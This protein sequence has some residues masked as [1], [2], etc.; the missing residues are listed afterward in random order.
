MIEPIRVVAENRSKRQRI[1]LKTMAM[2]HCTRITIT[3]SIEKRRNLDFER[4]QRGASTKWMKMLFKSI[5]S[6][7]FS[8]DIALFK[9]TF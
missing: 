5:I 2:A 1:F 4:G 7:L 8:F 6:D 9:F 3:D